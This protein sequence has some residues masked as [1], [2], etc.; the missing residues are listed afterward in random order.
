MKRHIQQ[1]LIGVIILMS[2]FT[3]NIHAESEKFIDMQDKASIRYKTN[4]TKQGLKF[5]ANVHKEAVEDV[6]GM[7]L[8]YGAT[9]KEELIAKINNAQ[10]ESF[11]INNKKVIHVKFS[12]LSEENTFSV[13]ITGIPESS[14]IDQVSVLAYVKVRDIIRYAPEV[15][16]KSIA[17]VAFKSINDGETSASLNQVIELM[18]QKIVFSY[19]ALNNLELNK[20][21]YEYNHKY[22]QK[23][24]NEDFKNI[25][26]LGFTDLETAS[27]DVF[28]FYQN[29]RLRE[30]WGFLLEYFL[31]L[32]GNE[33]LNGQIDNLKESKQTESLEELIYALTNFFNEEN[34]YKNENIIDFTN[35][36]YYLILKDYNNKI[37]IDPRNYEL[38]KIGDELVIPDVLADVDD[39]IGYAFD[40]FLVNEE[41]YDPFD[42]YI[43]TGN[44]VIFKKKYSY[45]EY[46]VTFLTEENEFKDK[47]TVEHN[48]TIKE[49]PEYDK[50]GFVIVYWLDEEGNMVNS[51]AQIIKDLV[52]KPVFKLAI[53]EINLVVDKNKYIVTEASANIE[54]ILEPK[55]KN[56]NYLYISPAE[57]YGFAKNIEI[58]VTFTDG[59]KA[60]YINSTIEAEYIEYIYDDPGW[61]G[62]Y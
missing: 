1:I 31:Y 26:V 36:E 12:N 60:K 23:E 56:Y 27:I 38:Y 4:E 51:K 25:N 28:K 21:F 2:L 19:N 16:T 47:R 6:Y 42:T 48:D 24:F 5:T 11:N 46:N 52:L 49:A 17:E 62:R 54:Y 40:Y 34:Y 9:T 32:S 43:I 61:T 41:R 53:Y 55:E 30:K 29:F 22:L 37:F 45:K 20:T 3:I 14:Y 7:Y 10:G 39:E 35:K 13:I 8:V 18:E 15:V 50:E 44:D 59:K 33:L 57:G 58:T